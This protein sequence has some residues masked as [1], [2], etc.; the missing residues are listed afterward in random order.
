MQAKDRC[1]EPAG[2]ALSLSAALEHVLSAVEPVADE[3]SIDLTQA[4]GRV[5]AAA[6][7]APIDVPPFANSAMDG[8]ALCRADL[9]ESGS[10]ALRV[11]GSAFAGRPYPDPLKAGECVRIFTGAAIPQGADAVIM[12]EEVI[13]EGDHARLP[14]MLKPF[15]NIRPAGDEIKAGECLLERGKRLSPADMGMLASAGITDVPCHRKIRVAFFSTGDELSPIG[16]PLAYGMIHDSNRYTLGALLDHPLIDATDLG[17]VRDD[18]DALRETLQE[19]SARADAILTTGGVSVGEADYVT[20]VLE[21][22]GQVNFWKIAVKP[23]KPFAFGRIGNAWLFGLP[24]NPVAV[25]VG[26]HTLVR[27]ALLR[28]SGTLAEPDLRLRA[29]CFSPL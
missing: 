13:R 9:A 11:A 8:Y 15:E 28:L 26:F 2:K 21:E 17:V 19:A 27:P 25:M 18:P 23:G 16:R 4:R 20:R 10:S 24:G 14:R 12:Q 29:T 22:I 5:L 6:I 7:T 3:E 1:A